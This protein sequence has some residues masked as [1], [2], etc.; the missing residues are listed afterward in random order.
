M[1]GV[2]VI[3][4]ASRGLGV[5]IA[6]SLAKPD[7]TL[8][9][10]ARDEA[11]LNETANVVRSVGVRVKIVPVDLSKSSDQEALIAAAENEGP[12]DIFINNVAVEYPL[13]VTEQSAA[14]VQR[15]IELNLLTPI[16]LT[17]RVLPGMIARKRGTVCMMSS[18]AG[19]SPTPYDAIYAATK[20]GLN[21]FV[22]SV[23]FELSGTGVHIGVV[24][25]SF[26]AE[27]GMW[28]NGGIKAPMMMR[29]VS[30]EKVVKGV[31]LVL[32]G[33]SEVL[34]TPGPVRP[35]LALAQLFPGANPTV[36]RALGVVDVMRRRALAEGKKRSELS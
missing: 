15:Q 36:L 8:V 21:G 14:D 32:A 9:L 7:T 31:R 34:V 10:A 23:R 17:R 6:R 16:L 30:V 35:L 25:P 26:V 27:S 33:K 3:T 1:S 29:E 18:M 5:A 28:M 20:H 22:E 12:I 4:G 13:P 11:G 24:C 19:K 2:T